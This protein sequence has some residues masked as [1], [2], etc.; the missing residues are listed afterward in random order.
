MQSISV[1]ERVFPTVT[2][3]DKGEL[4]Y[5]R[6]TYERVVGLL[7]QIPFIRSILKE[8]PG[9]N[10]VFFFFSLACSM[11]YYCDLELPS[12]PICCS[13]VLRT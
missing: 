4:M 3:G 5:M 10:S 9:N 7:I 1:G 6:E 8:S 13:I 11:C 12:W 2:K